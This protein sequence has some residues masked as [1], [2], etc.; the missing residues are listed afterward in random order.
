[1]LVKSLYLDESGNNGD[2]ISRKNGLGFAGQPVFSLAAVDVSRIENI[3]DKINGLKNKFGIQAEEL[4]SSDIFKKKPRFIFEIFSILVDLKCPFFVEV[5]DKKYYISTSISNHQLLP[6][7]FTGDE[8]NGHFQ[9]SRNIASGVMALEMPDEYFE[10]F[11]DSC[12]EPSEEVILKSMRGIKEFFMG[13]PEYSGYAKNLDMSIEDYYDIKE[14]IGDM[15]LFKFIPIPDEGKRGNKIFLLPHV[16]S[17]TNIIARVNLANKGDISGI[18]FFH[19][20]QDHFDEVLVSI[21]NLMVSNNP[22]DFSP[23]TPNSNFQ[24]KTSADLQF[25]DSKKSLGV[26]IADLLAGFFSRYYEAFFNA[27]MELDDIYHE[28]YNKIIDGSDQEKSVGVNWV[29]PP[30][31]LYELEHFHHIGNRKTPSSIDLLY[32][33]AKDFGVV[34]GD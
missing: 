9:I 5:V 6:P 15:A 11:F 28:I 4:K 16:S 30:S 13:H 32:Y 20:K 10:R 1:M 29:V 8:S 14:E 34:I 2:L 19:D 26:Q 22:N 24:V 17:L 18:T 25:S 7:Y 21:K 27:E 23:P 31:R 33:I 3:E 12:Y